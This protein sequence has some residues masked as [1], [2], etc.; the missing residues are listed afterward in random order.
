MVPY[1]T[2]LLGAFHRGFGLGRTSHLESTG[3]HVGQDNL[4][5]GR[6]TVQVG[7]QGRRVGLQGPFVVSPFIGNL[8]LFLPYNPGRRG[9]RRRIHCHDAVTPWIG[10]FGLVSWFVLSFFLSFFRDS[11]ECSGRFGLVASGFVHLSIRIRTVGV[12][13]LEME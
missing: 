7:L 5:F 10:A 11:L 8:A 12:V 2:Y 4:F 6:R 1:G 13:F 3:D 9:R